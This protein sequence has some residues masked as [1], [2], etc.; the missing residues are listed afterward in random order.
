MRPDFPPHVPGSTPRPPAGAFDFL[1]AG[2]EPLMAPAALRDHAAFKGGL[3][4]LAAGYCWEAHEVL[5]AVWLAA[6]PGSR[7]R[8]LVQALIQLANARLKVA[9]GQP[10]AAARIAALSG[11]S[12]REAGLGGETQVLGI[13]LAAVADCLAHYDATTGPA[14]ESHCG[15]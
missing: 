7:E 15:K 1:R 6:P 4:L 5:E 3:E 14:F 12:L 13:S 10:R 8:H 2:L 11:A 9:M